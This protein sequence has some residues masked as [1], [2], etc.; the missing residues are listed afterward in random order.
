MWV[1]SLGLKTVVAIYVIAI[2][3]WGG[4]HKKCDLR[5]LL[6]NS[7]FRSRWVVVDD[8]YTTLLSAWC[9]N[10]FF[11]V[12][13]IA[14]Y[15]HIYIYTS[16]GPRWWMSYPLS[17]LYFT[18]PT[19][20]CNNYVGLLWHAIEWSQSGQIWYMWFWYEK[21]IVWRHNFHKLTKL[22]HKSI[23]TGRI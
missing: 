4:D 3:I 23:Y 2:Y 15:I 19:R 6:N 21:T 22:I 9:C 12:H 10:S 11:F 7:V 14:T 17:R 8:D 1:Q 18:S 13:K 20:C 5:I 16:I